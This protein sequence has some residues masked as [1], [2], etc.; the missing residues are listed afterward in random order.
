MA[1]VALAERLD[2]RFSG[3]DGSLE[4]FLDANETLTG[5]QGPELPGDATAR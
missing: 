4:I 3:V 2:G 5:A 1:V